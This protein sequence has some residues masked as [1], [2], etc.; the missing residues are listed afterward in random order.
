MTISH[1]TFAK[2]YNSSEVQ[3]EQYDSILNDNMVTVDDLEKR[4][5][6]SGF[7]TVIKTILGIDSHNVSSSLARTMVGT[8]SCMNA[9][10][11]LN[12][13]SVYTFTFKSNSAAVLRISDQEGET[14]AVQVGTW[15]FNDQGQI[16]VNLYTD[17]KKQFDENRIF[18]L[19]RAEKGSELITVDYPKDYYPDIL[20]GIFK[21]IKK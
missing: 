9:N 10:T 3:K 18:T 17:G 5:N 16:V 7:L 8:Y 15:A 2:A 1:G 6:E 20:T 21:F 4:E 11:S 12:C 13:T 19:I 14:S